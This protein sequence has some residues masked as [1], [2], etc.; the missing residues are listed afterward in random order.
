M[1]LQEELG[2]KQAGF[3]GSRGSV[4]FFFSS[5]PRDAG[6]FP[7]TQAPYSSWKTE[8]SPGVLKELWA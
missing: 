8:W 4:D 3:Y 2:L 7:D 6:L 1:R 5:V